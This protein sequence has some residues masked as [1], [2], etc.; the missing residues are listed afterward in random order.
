MDNEKCAE[1]ERDLL[2]RLG[3]DMGDADREQTR[4]PKTDNY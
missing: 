3:E 2:R 4:A 1:A